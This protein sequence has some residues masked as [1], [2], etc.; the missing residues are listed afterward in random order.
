M[1]TVKTWLYFGCTVA[2]LFVMTSLSSAQNVNCSSEDGRRK[3]C[4]VDTRDGVRMVKQ[5]SD[6][7]CAQGST[8][9]YD[10]GGIWVD[11]GCR[12]DFIV[13]N[14]G[15]PG[16]GYG[17][18]GYG[19]PGYGGGS[20]EQ[21]NCSS[22]DGGR[23]YCPYNTRGGVRLIRQRSG[24]ACTQGSTWGYDRGGI[25]VDRGCRADFELGGGGYGGGPGRPGHDGPGWGNG[26]GAD[27]F[28]NCSSEDGHRQYCPV[29]TRGGVRLVK[30]RSDASCREG[31]SWG[32][33]RGGIWVDRGCRA[34]FQVVR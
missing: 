14:A 1:F 24:S 7:T 33:D 21:V 16:G 15:Y 29:N 18:P 22:E 31:Y 23:K 17:G 10:R 11:R 26:G 9:G 8:W 3:Y 6:A 30:Q 34:D 27:S 13:G 25:W 20:G 5:R 2:L 32:Y 28:L 19:G 4:P 12:A